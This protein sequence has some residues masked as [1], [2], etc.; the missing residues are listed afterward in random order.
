LWNASPVSRTLLSI[1]LI[2]TLVLPLVW[3]VFIGAAVGLLLHL[4]RTS[5][6][7]IRIM[8]IH[9]DRLLPFDSHISNVAVVEVSGTVHYAAA[10]P[11]LQEMDRLLPPAATIVI[12]D[13]SHAHELR[14]TSLRALEEWAR[15]LEAR[16]I[17]V[18]LAGVTEEVRGLLVGAGSHLP[19][20]MWDPVPGRSAIECY[21]DL[22]S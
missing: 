14:F 10:E 12:I 7:R 2:S 16:G 3:A 22:T 8:T 15:Q 20:N 5:T 4:A 19:Y 18:R 17:R 13:L 21:R 1:T 6:P 9:E 11:M